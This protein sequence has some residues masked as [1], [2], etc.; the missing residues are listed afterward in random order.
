MA[1]RAPLSVSV[2]GEALRTCFGNMAGAARALGVDRTTVWRFIKKHNELT[3]VLESMRETM[4]DNAETALSKAILAGEAWAVCFF[5]K[6]Q[7]RRRGYSATGNKT[8]HPILAEIRQAEA[9]ALVSL[10]QLLLTPRSRS[11]ARLATDDM[12]PAIEGATPGQAKL[13]KYLA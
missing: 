7:G 1:I 4:L 10:G 13:L 9:D 12:D 5:L 2:V 11:S 8:V 6:T 3:D